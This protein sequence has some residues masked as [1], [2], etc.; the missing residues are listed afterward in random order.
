MVGPDILELSSNL[1]DSRIC[2][3]MAF[4]TSTV[5][6]PK[7]FKSRIRCNALFSSSQG[8]CSQFLT[9]VYLH[10]VAVC[11][12]QTVLPTPSTTDCYRSIYPASCHYSL[13]SML[14]KTKTQW[15]ICSSVARSCCSQAL[16]LLCPQEALTAPRSVML[17]LYLGFACA[18]LKINFDIFFLT[19]I[20]LKLS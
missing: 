1:N 19:Q 9:V 17:Q 13:W 16:P 20:L 6:I 14:H 7:C 2:A 3:F 12:S 10:A 11:R 5:R 18:C 15:G 8:Y 4:G